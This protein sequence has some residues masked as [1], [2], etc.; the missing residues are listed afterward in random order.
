[1]FIFDLLDDQYQLV[2]EEPIKVE[3]IRLDNPIQ[4]NSNYSQGAVIENIKLKK[5]EYTINNLPTAVAN[6][7]VEIISD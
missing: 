2:A 7:A 4:K 3:N 1:M 5:D 6:T